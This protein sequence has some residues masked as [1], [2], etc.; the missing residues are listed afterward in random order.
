MQDNVLPLRGVRVLD[1][2]WVWIGPYCAK[3]LAMLGA[4]VIKVEGHKRTDLTRHSVVWPLP[5]PQPIAVPPNQGMSFN[6][7]NM[8]KKS[9]SIDLSSAEG[10]ALARRLALL[11]DVV[12]DN[13]RP[14]F[15][16]RIG[17]S[18]DQLREEKPDIIAVSCSSRGQEGPESRYAGYA[19]I[20]HAIGGATYITGYPD[21]APSHSSADTDLMNGTTAA[22]ATL[23]ALYHRAQTGQGQFIDYS[24]CEGVSSLIGE[25]LLGY[26]MN[27]ILPTRVAN[28]HE[29]Y[30]PHNVYRC[31]GVDRWLA[32]EIHT[33]DEF[34]ILAQVMGRPDL[35]SDPRFADMASR[36]RNEA[37]LDALVGQWTRTRDRDRTVN[38]LCEAGLAAAPSRDARD[39]YADR[40][41]R[42]R[43]ALVAIDHPELG[44]L[45]LVGAPWKMTGGKLATDRAPLL[46]EHNEYVLQDLLGLTGDEVAELRAAQVIV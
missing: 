43:E 41:L 22:F 8:N 21:D 26:E 18:Y 12:I 6:A 37:E 5:E 17:L 24:Q 7:L 42:A 33:D 44:E 2:C 14:G 27:G 20:H 11:S 35:A 16:H 39:L 38:E 4:E 25:L 30:A 40:H 45:Q 15:M 19:T 34:A 9:V 32:L 29:E 31:W 28:A 13:M 36:K 46:G 1:L 23:V 3:L 10:M